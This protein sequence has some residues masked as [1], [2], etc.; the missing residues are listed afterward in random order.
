[1]SHWSYINHQTGERVEAYQLLD[2]S[3]DNTRAYPCWLLDLFLE[4]RIEMDK[5][6]GGTWYLDR[7]EPI[8]NGSWIIRR[9]SGEIFI[10]GSNQFGVDFEKEPA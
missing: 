10:G 9:E 3:G 6:P 2:E 7:K 8:P 5:Y 4:S 1:M